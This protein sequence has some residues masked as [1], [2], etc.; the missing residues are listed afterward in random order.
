ML[1]TRFDVQGNLK[2]IQP[3]SVNDLNPCL[4]VARHNSAPSL[5]N[6]IHFGVNVDVSCRVPILQ[7][8]GDADRNGAFMDVYLNYTTEVDKRSTNYLVPVPVL[9]RG[10]STDN[11]VNYLITVKYYLILNILH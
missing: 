10:A 3:L 1:Q 6:W 4:S 9:V 11:L 5:M 8:I 2:T 7:L